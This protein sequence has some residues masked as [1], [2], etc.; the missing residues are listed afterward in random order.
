MSKILLA[1]AAT[2]VAMLALDFLWLG[3]I[4]KPLYRQ[5]IGHLMAEQ[6]QMAVAAAF[7]AFF[8]VGLMVFAVLPTATTAPWPKTA[9]TAALFG[10][11]CYATYDLTNLATLRNWPAGLSF[12]DMA[13][14]SVVSALAA[15]AGRAATLRLA[16]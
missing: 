12:I 7:Y 14:G 11:F 4:A 5:G 15:L 8:A 9:W 6:P 16:F 1:Y 2:L 10:L 13:W 3:L